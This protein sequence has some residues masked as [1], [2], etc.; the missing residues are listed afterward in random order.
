MLQKWFN[1]LI[2][3]IDFNT[4]KTAFLPYFNELTKFHFSLFN[5]LFWVF[6]LILFLISSRSWGYR[7]SFSYYSI[8]A[9]V[10]L[11]TTMLEN[12]LAS[13][14]A[15]SEVFDATV[16]RIISIFVILMVTLYYFFIRSD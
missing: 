16:L 7:K 6:L 12:S 3:N 10:L 1:R 5:P 15:K 9:I 14:L 2:E 4:L 11:T 13:T 8:L